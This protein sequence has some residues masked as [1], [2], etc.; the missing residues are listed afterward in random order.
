MLGPDVDFVDEGTDRKWGGR[1]SVD[2]RDGRWWSFAA[3]VGGVSIVRAIR[4]LCPDYTEA[5]A[6]G[7]VRSFLLVHEG[8]GPEAADV[9]NDTG[10]LRQLAHAEYAHELLDRAVALDGT[11]GQAYLE[12]RGLG[13]P[14]PLELGWVDQA[15]PGDGAI[16]ASL[17]AAGR[18]V[19]IL[20]TFIDASA[21]KSTLRPQ[22]MRLNLEAAQPGAA[23]LI[24]TEDTSRLDLGTDTIVV[25]GL[26]NLLSLAPLRNPTQRLVGLPG[27]DTLGHIEVRR[28]ERILVFQ[29]SD[30]EGSPAR[31]G[32]Q[33]GVDGFCSKAPSCADHFSELGG[34]S[35]VCKPQ[36]AALKKLLS[37][38]IAAALS[39]VARSTASHHYRATE[40]EG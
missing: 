19:A 34:S 39:L 8:N 14:Y 32:L 15:R 16:I 37:A 40:Y 24:P 5:D 31:E 9:D 20:L 4:F 3:S 13:P 2:R 22:R 29:D 36:V 7:H 18:T 1:I 30:P 12:T 6:V 28:G 26:E 10:E 21:R 23:L 27:I 33:R 25:E 38:P 11:D 17:T 35:A